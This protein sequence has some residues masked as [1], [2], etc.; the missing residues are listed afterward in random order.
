MRS[1]DQGGLKVSGHWP[2][3]W[4]AQHMRSL[5]K[6]LISVSHYSVCGCWRTKGTWEKECLRLACLSSRSTHPNWGEHRH[7]NRKITVKYGS[8]PNWRYDQSLM[9]LQRKNPA[10]CCSFSRSFIL[11]PC[12]KKASKDSECQKGRL[13]EGALNW[14]FCCW[15]CNSGAQ[16]R[17]AE[18]NIE[19]KWKEG[20]W[21][22]NGEF[23]VTG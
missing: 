9:G 16:G 12:I 17:Q 10:L 23:R 19:R 15:G 20:A 18:W 6:A 21:V 2:P 4:A 13:G 3:K 8:V 22:T 14:N 1:C 7:M 11:L 5:R